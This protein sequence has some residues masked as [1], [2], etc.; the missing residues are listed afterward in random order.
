MGVEGVEG[1]GEV[2]EIGACDE[3]WM[4]VKVEVGAGV[5]GIKRATQEEIL[6]EVEVEEAVLQ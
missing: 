4:E 3:V 2:T 1:V 5:K 6:P